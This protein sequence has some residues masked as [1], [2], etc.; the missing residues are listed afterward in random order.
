MTT[1]ILIILFIGVAIVCFSNI[2]A[3]NRIVGKRLFISR[4]ML[5][6]SDWL[7]IGKHF[8]YIIC[9]VMAFLLLVFLLY[10]FSYW[11][12]GEFHISY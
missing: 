12:S 10:Y 11:R 7:Q 6:K 5:T 3:I 1:G 4:N 8:L 9:G 2:I